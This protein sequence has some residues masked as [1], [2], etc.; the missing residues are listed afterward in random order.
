MEL[1]TPRS[2]ESAG[3]Q[4]W[5]C[6]RYPT[7][8]G[9]RDLA[10]ARSRDRSAAGPTAQQ[11]FD[12]ERVRAWTQ[13]RRLLPAVRGAVAALRGGA[14][15]ERRAETHLKGL[16][17]N[18]YVLL[19]DRL[20][21]G[22]RASIDHVVIGPTGVFVVETKSWQ[23]Q[24]AVESDRLFVDGRLRDGA[25]DKI[26]RAAA[27]VQSLL[28]GELRPLGV[29]VVPIVCFHRTDLPVFKG[30][31]RGVAITGGRGLLRAIRD[32]V[33]TLSPEAVQELALA[34]DDMLE[35]VPNS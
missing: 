6:T 1:H 7:C 19:H 26:L 3:Q 27:D 18:G 30:T 33:P 21:P 34:A 35:P 31:V 8:R 28:V 25:A 9:V 23:G 22:G 5:R 14:G 15:R 4:F 29:T 17:E 13:R 32:A 10:V 2:G 16:E 20:L 11:R 24:L 12:K